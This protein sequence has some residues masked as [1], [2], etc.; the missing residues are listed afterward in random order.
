MTTD[1]VGM[2][3]LYLEKHPEILPEL[4][5]GEDAKEVALEYLKEY[6]AKIK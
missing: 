5:T 2:A 6:N 3:K 1:S 4:S